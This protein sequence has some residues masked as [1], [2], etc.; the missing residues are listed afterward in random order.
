MDAMPRFLF[1]L[2]IFRSILPRHLNHKPT[3][4]R[5]SGTSLLP[6]RQFLSKPALFLNGANRA[7]KRLE[8]LRGPIK[9]INSQRSISS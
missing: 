6:Q 8:K 7:A 5:I 9:V 2:H 1:Q 3:D 4:N